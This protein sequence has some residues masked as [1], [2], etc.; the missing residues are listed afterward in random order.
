MNPTIKKLVTDYDG[1]EEMRRELNNREDL[2]D[3]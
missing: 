3:K 1:Y 2:T